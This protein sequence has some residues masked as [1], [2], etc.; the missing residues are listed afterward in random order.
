MTHTHPW[1]HLL[2]HTHSH[3]HVHCPSQ[4]YPDTLT[5]TH[6]CS[7]LT[8]S[9][10]PTHSQ[11]C[12]HTHIQARS[13]A[14]TLTH[15]QM[16]YT[17]LHPISVLRSREARGPSV[18]L[19][20]RTQPRAHHREQK[21]HSPSMAGFSGL[22]PPPGVTPL[23][24]HR[25]LLKSSVPDHRAA[26]THLIGLEQIQEEVQFLHHIVLLLFA[27]GDG[28][29]PTL[30]PGQAPPHRPGRPFPRHTHTPGTH[31]DI[32]TDMLT[33][34]SASSAEAHP[35]HTAAQPTP[36]EEQG[37]ESHPPARCTHC[38]TSCPPSIPS[39]VPIFP[40]CTFP[41]QSFLACTGRAGTSN[42]LPQQ[43]FHVSFEGC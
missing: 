19:L 12:S 15:T 10:I 21:A 8:R 43:L 25:T 22:S 28:V 41:A 33:F 6:S 18:H 14:D 34:S 17:G 9:D 1:T 20:G 23:Q 42:A 37:P 38:P 7:L 31:S 13:H 39:H 24:G 11:T 29:Y 26:E 16:L 30:R 36:G 40:A 27:L 3:A 5:R 4:T 2:R 32:P 35:S